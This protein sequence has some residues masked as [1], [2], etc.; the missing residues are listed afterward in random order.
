MFLYAIVV[1]APLWGS[2][3]TKGIHI[4]KVYEFCKERQ[5]HPPKRKQQ[6]ACV[7]TLAIFFL[8]FMLVSLPRLGLFLI[9]ISYIHIYANIYTYIYI[10]IHK[11]CIYGYI[12][13]KVYEILRNCAAHRVVG[14]VCAML[15]Y[16]SF[17]FF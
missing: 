3:T 16:F 12:Y 14:L 1:P 10:F 13:F 4:Y 9:P 8:I 7:G 17:N 6:Y 11:R 2:P 15:V 5:K